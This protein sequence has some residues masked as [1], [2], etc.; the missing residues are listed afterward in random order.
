MSVDEEED[1]V[2]MSHLEVYATKLGYILE[3][4]TLSKKQ[5]LQKV[6]DIMS[7]MLHLVDEIEKDE[8]ERRKKK[9]EWKEK[10]KQYIKKK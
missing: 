6:A 8:K 2:C 4:M 7:E 1:Q 3:D 9:R 10:R 5:I